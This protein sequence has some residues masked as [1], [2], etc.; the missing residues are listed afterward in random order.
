MNEDVIKAI[1]W[2]NSDYFQESELDMSHHGN[3]T[4]MVN[5]IGYELHLTFGK[6]S[7]L[8][9]E[10]YRFNGYPDVLLMNYKPKKEQPHKFLLVQHEPN[11]YEV[12]L[13][14]NVIELNQYLNSV[15]PILEFDY[16]QKNKL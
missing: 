5:N 7:G 3:F 14:R 4:E 13:C 1:F 9:V 15:M 16:W 11:S 6:R 12:V 10:M 2:T 8:F